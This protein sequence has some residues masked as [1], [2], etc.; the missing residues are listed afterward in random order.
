M[1]GEPIPDCSGPG[2]WIAPTPLVPAPGNPYR[3]YIFAS[4]FCSE[5]ELWIAGG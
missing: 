4:T 1:G 5:T 2:T 3:N